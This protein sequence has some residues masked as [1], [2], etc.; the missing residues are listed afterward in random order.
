MLVFPMDGP[1]INLFSYLVKLVS[2]GKKAK[3]IRKIGHLQFDSYSP[4]AGFVFLLDFL[5]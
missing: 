3:N 2:W 4:W 5:G 1:G